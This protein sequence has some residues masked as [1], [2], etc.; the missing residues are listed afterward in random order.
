MQTQEAI[1][2]YLL[3]KKSVTKLNIFLFLAEHPF[4]IT[5]HYLADYFEMSDSNFLLYL[6]ELEQDF[7]TL[8]LEDVS[9]IRQKKFVQLDLKNTDSAKCYYE[10]FGKY[11]LESTNFKI[12]TALL[13]PTGH[14]I[15]SISQTTNY[16]SSYLYSKMKA[17]NQFLKLYGIAFKFT[18]KGK[19]I[20]AGTEVQIQ[21]CFLDVY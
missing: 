5:T 11:C 8:D 20:V 2:K 17:V 10:L 16:S 9:L 3:N 1:K 7:M 6:Q 12:L 21:Y 15:V 18:A 4:F 13:E 14:S 19:K